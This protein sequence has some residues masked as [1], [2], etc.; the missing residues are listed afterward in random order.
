M[1]KDL[2][3]KIFQFFADLCVIGVEVAQSEKQRKEWFLRGMWWNDYCILY[4]D[5]YLD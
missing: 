2:K 4:H 3:R 5:M 1:I